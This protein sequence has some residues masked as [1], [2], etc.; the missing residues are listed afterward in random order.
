[1][2]GQKNWESPTPQKHQVIV[3]ELRTHNPGVQEE[4][5]PC[6]MCQVQDKVT[7][8]RTECWS[9]IRILKKAACLRNNIPSVVPSALHGMEKNIKIKYDNRENFSD[10][11][12]W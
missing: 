12:P 8:I 10:N 6:Q 4:S 3:A 11:R 5:I 2:L 9:N 1:M 7:P